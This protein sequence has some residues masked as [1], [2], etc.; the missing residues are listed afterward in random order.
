MPV[1]EIVGT[2]REQ[3]S[4]HRK[5]AVGVSAKSKMA[6]LLADKRIWFGKTWR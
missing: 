3:S 1:Y 5:G 4:Y 2:R 6:E